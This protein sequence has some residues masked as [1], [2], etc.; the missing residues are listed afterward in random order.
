VERREDGS[1][2]RE[3]EDRDA[4]WLENESFVAKSDEPAGMGVCGINSIE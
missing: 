3:T 1:G 4:G 2:A